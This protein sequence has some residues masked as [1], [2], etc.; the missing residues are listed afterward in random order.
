MRPATPF[1]T[2]WRLVLEAATPLSIATGRPDEARDTVLAHDANGLPFIPGSSL[3]GALRA[4]A[5]SAL[6]AEPNPAGVDAKDTA[7]DLCPVRQTFGDL[8]QREEER[9]MM[10]RLEISH[11]H[12]HNQNDQ[13]VTG[14]DAG[15]DKDPLLA[16]LL[17]RRNAQRQRVRINHRGAADDRGLFNRSVL[18][19]GHRFT[20]EWVLWSEQDQPVVGQ[21]L[22]RLLADGWLRVGALSRSGLGSLRVVR[23]RRRCFDLRQA[24]DLAAWSQLPGD[25]GDSADA[26]LTQALPT[27]AKAP[28]GSG[29]PSQE[30]FGLQRLRLTLHPE[31][32]FR[33]GG[34]VRSL[35]GGEGKANADVPMS[36]ARVVW[37]GGKGR[38][39]ENA[40]ALIPA[41]GLKGA[42]SHRV[43]FH[44]NRLAGIWATPDQVQGYD[45]AVDCPTVR[46]L[47][48]AAGNDRA[49][50]A[51]QGDDH[52]EQGDS[53]KARA[54]VLGFADH[55]LQVTQSAGQPQAVQAQVRMHNHIDRFTG[56]VRDSLLFGTED[57]Y[58]S[59]PD[60]AQP[61]LTLDITL[62]E[63]R[64]RAAGG[65]DDD[66]RALRAAVEDLCQGR[67]ALGAD[68]AGGL[69]FFTGQATW[70]DGCGWPADPPVAAPASDTPCTENQHG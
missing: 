47:F 43:A 25:L 50:R 20:V 7:A 17:H 19:A 8:A 51:E 9:G 40:G 42:L 16:P 11:A 68:S 31:G 26:V 1:V 2:V 57:L 29:S 23:G 10:S 38:L 59:Q 60:P 6:K 63:R 65:T 55:W 35:L 30:L 44:A 49:E 62:D 12:I 41:T 3:A 52:S 4:L 67:L 56:G 32:G 28:A 69:G 18:P 61:L 5:P 46:R 48:G 53:G 15:L 14:L 33:F 54:G 27:G 36:E 70:V 66:L 24:R 13:P 22:E 58:A 45:K 64:L 34:G 39:D 37:S 21:R